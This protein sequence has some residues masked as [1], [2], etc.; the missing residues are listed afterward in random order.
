MFKYNVHYKKF[1]KKLQCPSEWQR[2]FKC[3]TELA[4]AY[5]PKDVEAVTEPCGYF[6][7]PIKSANVFSVV[8]P[9]PNIT[10][11]LH[12]GHALTVTIQDVLAR[13]NRMKGRNVVWV[14]G[15]DHAGIATQ[16]I[17]EKRLWQEK[18]QTRH[19]L[20]RNLLE[21]E[22][23]KWKREKS[24]T[25]GKQL[26]QLGSLLT[27][28]M[29]MFS[30]DAAQS[31]AVKEAF[32]RLFDDGLIYRGD[33]LVNWSCILQSAISDIE[34]EHVQVNGPT[35]LPVPGYEEPVEFGVLYKF[36]YKL[37]DYDE[38][39][40]VATT[41]P[42]TMLGDIAIAVNAEDVRYTTFVGRQA[43]HPFRQ[44]RI[45]IIADDCVNPE[46]GTGAVKITP[47]H[48]P[49]DFEVGKRHGLNSLQI[50]DKK[51]NLTEVT[52]KFSG[53]SRFHAR[54]IIL[55]ELQKLNL[56]RG[57]Q[58]HQMSVPI[59]GRSRD[60]V[61]FLIKPQWFIKMREMAN[62]AADAVKEGKLKID[63]P[64]FEKTWLSWLENIRDWCVSR[65][66]WWGHR[67][68]V[69]LCRV[70]NEE[71]FCWVASDNLEHARC[72]A[73]EKLSANP[74]NIVVVQDEDVLDT[75]FSSALFPFSAFGWPQ[76]TENLSNYYPLSLME[77]GH[78]ILFFWVSRM[79]MM[80][81]QL[82]GKLPFSQILLHG[83]ICDAYGR[84][85]SKSLGNVI[86]PENVIF[87]STTEDLENGLRECRAAGILSKEELI[88][89]VE[90]QRKMFPAGIP[91]CGVDALRF[92]LCSHNIKNHFLNFDA[93]ECNTN[94]LFCNKIWQS[95]KYTIKS[96]ENV[97]SG[98]TLTIL[99]KEKLS[100]T[101]RWILSRLSRMVS[102]VNGALEQN[103]FHVAVAALKNFL[104]YEFCDVYLE[105][106]KR[107]MK[108]AESE[109]SAGHCSTLL[110]CLD[111]GLRT[112]A[113]FMPYLS[114]HLHRHLPFH[115]NLPLELDFPQ[116][117][118]WIDEDV[119]SQVEKF[120]ETVVAVRRLKK[121][122][123]I[124]AKHKTEVRIVSILPIYKELS[125]VMEDLTG[126]HKV[127][128]TSTQET[129]SEEL[130]RD[131]V[132]SHAVIY[133]L[134]PSELRKAFEMDS[135]K[136]EKKKS[137]LL[138]ELGKIRKMISAESYR[139]NAPLKV[140]QAHTK[141]IQSIEDELSRMN[142]LE[143]IVQSKSLNKNV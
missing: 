89:A 50:I 60:V 24:E 138:G 133:L 17:V 40:M 139:I 28:P 130:V 73:S 84:K 64:H 69:Y 127:T 4:A 1:Y 12:L 10:G 125:G 136:L 65:Q 27:W 47:A 58:D 80:G 121:I 25:I 2:R 35:L 16:V 53:V 61:E 108:S 68:P 75:W 85:M 99:D 100:I 14:P 32:I 33:Y 42:E 88:R 123:N 91:A 62:K 98:R 126:R 46:F 6:E 129:N 115:L 67:I 86:T 39:I 56:L 112:L 116:N 135:N 3:T 92:T 106:T 113:P 59:C 30:M 140:Q 66:L 51:G 131:V 76:Q 8:L 26:R 132:G 128:V 54:N 29:E 34:V 15:L 18:K 72:K 48:D 117:L 49:T 77:T 74:D 110:V 57:R 70:K 55:N 83:I 87:G 45:P 111:V 95:T 38:E 52:G 118:K 122:F 63:P 79:V 9:P 7:P 97:S 82:M 71:R 119:E 93:N 44:E 78:D 105:T 21:D 124:S 104:Y 81:T 5:V 11:S 107:D 20:G 103:E 90:G 94:R 101:D 96:I 114:R 137:K 141:K 109:A 19:D 43:W 143:N 102:N 142:H 23:W 120:L 31:H 22:L 41:R 37:A 134:L 13:W 36:A